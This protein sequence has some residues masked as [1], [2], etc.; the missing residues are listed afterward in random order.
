MAT[1]IYDDSEWPLFRVLMPPQPM[2]TSEFNAYLKHIDDLFLRGS[3]FAMVIDARDAP[4]HSP[5]E[6]QEIAKHMKASHARFP[7]RL[8][9][10]GIVMSS[11][12]QRGIFTAIMWVAGPTYP[13][14][15]FPSMTDAEL[16][17]REMLRARA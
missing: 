1:P 14:R 6:R 4:V 7:H 5:T 10:M 11:P 12:L 17:L 2:S 13:M 3:R 16:W 8:A 9:A 15:P